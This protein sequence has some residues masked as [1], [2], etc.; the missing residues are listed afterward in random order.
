MSE[1][2]DIGALKKTLEEFAKERDWEQFHVPKNLAM[3]LSTEAGELLEIFQWLTEKQAT[4]I[5]KDEETFGKV[6]DE[7]AD[8]VVYAILLCKYLDIDLPNAISNKMKKNALKYP[9][10]KAR[11]NA[12]KYNEL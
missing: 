7:I 12:K 10:D 9:V 2:L 1:V 11:G 3:A 6:Q 8:V 5:N 4:R